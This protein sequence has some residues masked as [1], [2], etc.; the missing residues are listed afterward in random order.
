MLIILNFRFSI[1]VYDEGLSFMVTNYNL[2]IYS[3]FEVLNKDL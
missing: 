2:S 3:E 1:K